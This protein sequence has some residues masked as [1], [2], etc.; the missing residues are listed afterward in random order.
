MFQ[1]LLG[2]GQ[3]SGSFDPKREEFLSF[4]RVQLVE[5]ARTTH[6]SQVGVFP[7]ALERFAKGRPSA[8][9]VAVEGADSGGQILLQPCSSLIAPLLALRLSQ[10]DCILAVAAAG[11]CG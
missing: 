10:A 5:L 7:P 9:R 1:S 8:R 6:A 3:Y 11:Q 4:T 2:P